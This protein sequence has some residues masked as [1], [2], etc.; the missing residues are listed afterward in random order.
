MARSS[1]FAA[2]TI[3]DHADRLLDSKKS[4]VQRGV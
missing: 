4:A 2:V 3:P 1:G